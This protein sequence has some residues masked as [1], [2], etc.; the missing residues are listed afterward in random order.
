MTQKGKKDQVRDMFNSIAGKYDFL[1]HFLS[2][3]IDHLWRKSLVR[4]IKKQHPNQVLDIATGTGDLAVA[5]AKALPHTKIIGADISEN[6]L[7][8]GKQ[9][10]IKKD[11]SD[12]VL[13]EMGDSEN[14]KYTDGFFDAVMVAFGV[15]NYEDLDKGLKEMNRV[16]KSG[17]QVYILEF[18]RPTLFPFKQIYNFYF[19]YILP[20]FGKTV[21]K[22]QSAYTYLPESVQKFPD[23]DDFL[24]HLKKAGYENVEQ[25]KLTLGVASIYTGKKTNKNLK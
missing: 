9:K 5:V 18:S 21:S 6:M 20:L 25:K 15:R 11:L 8:I 13:M 22:D 1:N 19:L 3:G 7:N 14:L 2:L 12:R 10:M 16:T 23:G 4:L 24:K 17:G